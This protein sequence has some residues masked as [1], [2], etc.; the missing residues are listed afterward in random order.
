[1]GSMVEVTVKSYYAYH[2]PS[3]LLITLESATLK[4]DEMIATFVFQYN[5]TDRQVNPKSMAQKARFATALS[6]VFELFKPAAS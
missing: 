6:V 3:S 2:D 5:A 4:E 1:M